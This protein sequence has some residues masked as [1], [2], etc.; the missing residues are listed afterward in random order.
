MSLLVLFGLVISI[1]G[2]AFLRTRLKASRLSRLSWDDLVGRLKPVPFSGISTIAVDYLQPSKGQIDIETN[3]L[4]A[5][6]GGL[7]GLQ[8]MYANA[9]ILIALAGYAQRWNLDESVIVAERMRRDGIKLR[10]ATSKLSM[11]FLVGFGVHGPFHVQEAASAYYLMR[12]R[13][14]ALYETSHVGRY[15][16]LAAAL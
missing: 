3:E 16:R 8:S 1:F 6:I 15:S 2:F 10:R 9:E 5:M 4:W 12:R 14:L 7:E 13:L 11:S